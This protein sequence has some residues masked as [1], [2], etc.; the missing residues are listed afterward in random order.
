MTKRFTFFFAALALAIAGYAFSVSNIVH[1]ITYSP[2][3]KGFIALIKGDSSR[4][5]EE[6][7]KQYEAGKTYNGVSLT[8]MGTNYVSTR[9]VFIPYRTVDGVWRMRI[10][11]RGG[12]SSGTITSIDLT[13]SGVLFN[14]TFAAQGC[15]AMVSGAA[16]YTAAAE[17]RSDS[18]GLISVY[19]PSAATPNIRVSCDVELASKPTWAD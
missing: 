17:A 14:G 4:V 6:K 3:M 18:S 11:T 1:S 8:I 15:A 19:F 7:A 12:V 16:P 9:A 13:V 2:Q 10:N 5:I